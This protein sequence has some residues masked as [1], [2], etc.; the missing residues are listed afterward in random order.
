MV[1]A[2]TFQFIFAVLFS[3]NTCQFY[4]YVISCRIFCRSIINAVS[5][6]TFHPDIYSHLYTI[7]PYVRS[8]FLCITRCIIIITILCCNPVSI[9]LICIM[10]R[11]NIWIRNRKRL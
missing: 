10:S 9:F 6:R 8:N 1:R 7:I 3:R 11:I 2:M 4:I 5:I